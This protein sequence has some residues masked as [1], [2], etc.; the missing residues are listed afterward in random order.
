MKTVKNGEFFEALDGSTVGEFLVTKT[1]HQNC[2]AAASRSSAQCEH[3]LERAR[4]II[5]E[6]IEKE[7][8]NDS[9]DWINE[10]FKNNEVCLDLGDCT[11]CIE[12]ITAEM[13]APVIA[14]REAKK[15]EEDADE[16]A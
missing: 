11:I 5:C 16:E 8:P 7:S 1:F 3:D 6:M 2:C 15:A 10:V 12:K 13:L 9:Q 4:Q 14:K